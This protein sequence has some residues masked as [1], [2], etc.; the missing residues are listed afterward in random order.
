ME[1]AWRV[2]LAESIEVETQTLKP[3][4]FKDPNT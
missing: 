2:Q 1:M 3:P 4:P